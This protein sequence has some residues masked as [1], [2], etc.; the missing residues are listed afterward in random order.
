M[1]DM[2]WLV[3]YEDVC[4]VELEYRLKRAI[5]FDLTVGLRSNFY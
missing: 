5:T 1:L 2:E 4:L 3:G